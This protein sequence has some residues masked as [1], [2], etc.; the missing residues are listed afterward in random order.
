MSSLPQRGPIRVD[1]YRRNPR[2]VMT[3][4]TTARDLVEAWASENSRP[5][6]TPPP[7]GDD[8][9]TPPPAAGRLALPHLP[10]ADAA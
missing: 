1:V 9:D 7:A 4:L 10:I 8:D 2:R 3:S 5:I 6:V